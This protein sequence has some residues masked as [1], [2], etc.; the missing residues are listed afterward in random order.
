MICRYGMDRL[1]TLT[2]LFKLSFSIFLMC[3]NALSTLN[4]SIPGFRFEQF[5]CSSLSVKNDPFKQDKLL[6][7]VSTD[8]INSISTVSSLRASAQALAS[9]KVILAICVLDL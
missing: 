9:S 3:S 6:N 8:D 4:K 1:S 5:A 2:T 7:I